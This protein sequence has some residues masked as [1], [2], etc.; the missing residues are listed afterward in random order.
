[1]LHFP[2]L[3]DLA[4]GGEGGGEYGV[5]PPLNPLNFSC[6][7]TGRLKVAG[8][9]N[10]IGE[11]SKDICFFFFLITYIRIFLSRYWLLVAT[12][13][14]VSQIQAEFN[15]FII[16]KWPVFTQGACRVFTSSI[17]NEISERFSIW[18]IFWMSTF[19]NPTC[20]GNV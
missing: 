16:Y 6:Y 19:K 7:A 11:N 3:R 20:F 10:Y 14:A 4:K 2:Y 17:R 18:W 8:V 13:Q 5:S 15:R 12:I 9:V 1:M